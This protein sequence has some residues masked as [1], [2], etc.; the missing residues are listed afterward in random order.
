MEAKPPVRWG[1]E[2]IFR[3]PLLAPVFNPVVDRFSSRARKGNQRLRGATGGL[4]TRDLLL[5][6]IFKNPPRPDLKANPSAPHPA[7]VLERRPLLLMLQPAWLAIQGP[8][9]RPRW[10]WG[11]QKVGSK[12]LCSRSP[13]GGV[14]WWYNEDRASVPPCSCPTDLYQAGL[15]VKQRPWSS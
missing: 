15:A 1:K 7:T 14:K 2:I 9:G 10:W 8:P 11:S 4:R 6:L 12:S 13:A 3:Q 5:R